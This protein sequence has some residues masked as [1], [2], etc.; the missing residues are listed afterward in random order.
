[1]RLS[2]WAV[3][4]VLCTL[5]ILS[6][7]TLGLGKVVHDHLTPSAHKSTRSEQKVDAPQGA[8]FP[9]HPAASRIGKAFA[10]GQSPAA[11]GFACERRAGCGDDQ[12]GT[13]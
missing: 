2:S 6:G 13:G 12:L 11:I 8:L 4:E 9:F 7:S 1:L 5:Q 10:R 3:P